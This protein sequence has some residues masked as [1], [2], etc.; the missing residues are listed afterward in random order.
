MRLRC[1]GRL[2]SRLADAVAAVRGVRP[3]AADQAEVRADRG[4]TVALGARGTEHS[5]QVKRNRAEGEECENDCGDCVSDGREHL[6]PS[7]VAVPRANTPSC[8]DISEW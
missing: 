1:G 7:I 2:R 4:G 3:A 6:C 5:L 8:P